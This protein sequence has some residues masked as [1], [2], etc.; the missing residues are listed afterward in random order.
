MLLIGCLVGW[1]GWLNLDWLAGWPARCRVIVW[2][3]GLIIYVIIL[4]AG[5]LRSWLD[6]GWRAIGWLNR[7]CLAPWLAG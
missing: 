7:C 1:F 6:I 3:I 4:H 5:W 2:A